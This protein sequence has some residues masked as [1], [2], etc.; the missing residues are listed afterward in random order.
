MVIKLLFK[1]FLSIKDKF[2]HVSKHIAVVIVI[3]KITVFSV[4]VLLIL[5]LFLYITFHLL[6]Y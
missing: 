6:L 5:F 4:T 2:Q 3:W 1:Y